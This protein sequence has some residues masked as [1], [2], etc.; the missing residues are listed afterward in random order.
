MKSLRIFLLVICT[1]TLTF[2]SDHEFRGVVHAIES[3]YGV[4]HLHI[5]LLGFALFFARSE[6]VRGLKLAVFENF[7]VPTAVDDVNRIVGNSLGPGWYPFVRVHS[8]GDGETTLIYAN[9]SG[10]KLRMMIVN[11]ESSEATVVELK[12]SQHAIKEWIDE[13]TEKA[14]D[15]SGHGCH[16]C[17]N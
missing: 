10:A 4:H 6:G 5:P 8:K 2:G 14:K 17:D 3:N 16:P 7:H 9:P 1:S 13:P 12:L 11:V 15:Q